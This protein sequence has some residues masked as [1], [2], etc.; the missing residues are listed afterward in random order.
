MGDLITCTF[1]SI[2][3][4]TWGAMISSI[5][6]GTPAQVSLPLPPPLQGGESVGCI[7]LKLNHY[8]YSNIKLTSKSLGPG[9]R[10]GYR[11]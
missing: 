5:D 7:F 8:S 2:S 11:S 6:A 9:F 3:R 10:R 4:N 1:V